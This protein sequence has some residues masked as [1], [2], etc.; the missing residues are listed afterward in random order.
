MPGAS[1]ARWLA[2]F[3]LLFCAV[4]QCQENPYVYVK[5]PLTVPW[6]LYFVFL[7]AVLIP[8]VVMIALAW[9]KQPNDESG[10]TSTPRQPPIESDG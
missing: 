1:R 5:M 10:G 2:M 9:R 8:F 6:A 3:P 4:G 7:G